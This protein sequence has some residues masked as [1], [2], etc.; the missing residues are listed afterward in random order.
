MVGEVAERFSAL[1]LSGHMIVGFWSRP[2]EQE[3]SKGAT[4]RLRR[5]ADQEP[6]V[7]AG[8]V[9]PV[10]GLLGTLSYSRGFALW[11]G[12]RPTQVAW[13]TGHAV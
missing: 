4:L 10:H 1:S 6:V 9:V 7:L 5:R 2:G 13:Q 11:L 3:E 12:L 8:S